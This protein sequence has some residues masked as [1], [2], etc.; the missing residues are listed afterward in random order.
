[1][2]FILDLKNYKDFPIFEESMPTDDLKR[3]LTA[4]LYTDVAGYSRLTGGDEEGTHRRV[5][6]LLD[7][8]SNQITAS[9][10]TVLRYAGDAIL[11]EFSSIVGAVKT[12]TSIQTE[13]FNKNAALLDDEKLQIRIGINI[14]DVIEDRGEVFGDGVNLAARLES[15]APEGGICISAAVHEQIQGKLET[16]FSDDGLQQFKNIN[17]PVGIFRWMPVTDAGDSVESGVK[18]NSEKPSIAVLALT[19]MSNDPDQDYIGDGISEDLITALSKIRSFKVIS[20]E[21]TFSYKGSSIDIRQIAKE[22]GV[23]YVLEGSVRRSGDR[24]RVTAQLIDAT[25]GHHVWAERYDREMEDIFDLQDEMVQIIAGALE[26]ELNAF[27]REL[28]VSKPPGN[29]DAWEQYQRAL[30]HMWSF[31]NNKVLQAMDMFKQA[32][33]S[34]PKFAPAHAYFAYS[35]YITVILG[36]VEDPEAR[37][38]EGLEAANQA[39][40]CD[41]KDAISYFAFA[42]IRMMQGD[43]DA[44]VAALRKSIQLNPCFAQSYHGLGFALALSGELEAAKETTQKAIDMSPRDPMLWAFHGVHSITLLLNQ[45]FQDALESADA[46]LRIPNCA[47]YW[48]HAVKAAAL[49]NLDRIADAKKALAD[50][51]QE[52]PDLSIAFLLGNLPTKHDGG[53]EPYIQGMLKAG[54][55]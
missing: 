32:I 29:L 22:L 19:N 23:G 47:G 28:A 48:G 50:A 52:K 39:L 2:I 33:E 9:G 17:R 35:C 12:G 25:T 37:L 54:L 53:L 8:V 6:E 30:W 24:V 16:Q 44:S 38:A 55:E 31:E 13:L 20:R 41:E 45:E 43:H 10:G 5:M 18:R 42:R 36:Y 26:P 34:D 40:Q 21:S 46:C 51:K 4:I 14:G 1:L 11:A 7:D 49:G 27:E 15:V 3:K